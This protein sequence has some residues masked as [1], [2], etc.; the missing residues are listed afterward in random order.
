MQSIGNDQYFLIIG[1]MKSATT[2]L[3]EYLAEH[4]QICASEVK[5]PE[6]F[7]AQQRPHD[8]RNRIAAYD[9]LWHFEP[10]QH[11]YVME[12]STGYAKYEEPGVVAAIAASGIRPKFAYILRDPF[13]RI[14]SQYNFMRRKPDWRQAIT[15]PELVQ[16]SNYYRFARTYAEAFGRDALLLLDYDELTRDPLETVNRVCGF[17]GIA[18]MR[19]LGNTG[20][21]NAAP[22]VKSEV[23]RAF[24]R[25]A[26]G[27]LR[28]L[29]P[30]LKAAV[31]DGFAWFGAKKRRLRP[32]ERRKIAAALHDDM[33]RLQREY[34]VDVARW[35]FFAAQ[36]R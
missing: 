33:I 30:G 8:T 6:Y 10:G 13:A 23:E 18:P 3:F 29:P 1:A 5:E 2:S 20:V 15:D 4:P 17:L 11:A 22:R 12:A 27:F 16:T 21:H 26:P 35:G 28:Q 14:E 9:D 24:R 31:R 7:S 19:A 32:D 36:P 25:R 34:G